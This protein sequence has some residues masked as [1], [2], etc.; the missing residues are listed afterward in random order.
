MIQRGYFPRE[1]REDMRKCIV[2]IAVTSFIFFAFSNLTGASDSELLRESNIAKLRAEIMEILRDHQ[3]TP[4]YLPGLGVKNQLLAILGTK[5]Y[6][7][8]YYPALDLRGFGIRSL[9]FANIF[10]NQN[11]PIHAN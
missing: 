10:L 4:E 2:I 7:R 5:K 3:Y 1:S 6:D 8:L 9:H 11:D